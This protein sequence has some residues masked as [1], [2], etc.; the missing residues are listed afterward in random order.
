MPDRIYNIPLRKEAMK[1]PRYMR[2][3]KAMRALKEF[4]QKHIKQKDIKIGKYLNQKILER[5]KYHFPHHV[6][7]RVFSE[8]VGEKGKEEEVWKAELVGAPVEK[9]TVIKEEKKE[10]KIKVGEEKK[11]VEAEK[12]EKEK[13]EEEK[14]IEKESKWLEKKTRGKEVK[15]AKETGYDEALKTRITKKEKPSHLRKSK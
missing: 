12:K 10:E 8:K 13:K 14:V 9:E 11:E 5:G 15:P 3:N 7:V 1:A 6:K 4:L 2:A